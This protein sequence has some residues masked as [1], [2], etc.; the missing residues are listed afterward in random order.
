[1][2]D[3]SSGAWPV[4]FIG[5]GV[6]GRPIALNLARAGVPLVVWNRSADRLAPLRSL[7]V[8][9]AATVADVFQRTRT[10]ILMLATEAAIDG[11]LRRGTVR[12]HT[13]VNMGSTAPEYSLSLHADIMAAGGR[14]VEAPVSGSRRP[15]EMATLVAMVAGAP[16]DV[17]T[18]RP[19]LAPMCRTTVPCGP[20]PAGSLMKL[21]VNTFML[22]M[23]AG[24]AEAAQFAARHGIDLE[25]FV[26][27]VDA[28]PLASD[29][30]RVKSRKL[31]ARDFSVQAFATDA[32]R[33]QALIIDAASRAGV[34]TPMLAQCHALYA[35]ML[36]QG[37]GE[38][39]MIGVVRA[40]EARSDALR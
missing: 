18:V 23:L 5:L 32:F 22:T 6:M 15:A 24:L 40:I 12:N 13:V 20:V 1:M 8:P 28:S 33:N 17:E 19:L 14:S 37:D 29:A 9:I 31:A 25:L 36:A 34:A 35:E 30:S 7:E 39:D 16:A 11:V 10:V 27:V 38:L 21:S 3:P 26:T 2:A 4:G